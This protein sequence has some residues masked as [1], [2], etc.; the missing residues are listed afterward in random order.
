MHYHFLAFALLVLSGIFGSLFGAA[1]EDRSKDVSPAGSSAIVTPVISQP[2]HSC[3]DG[4]RPYARG[5]A[6]WYG[7]GFHGKLMANG[8]RYDMERFTVAHKTLPLG[9]RVCITNRAN[10]QSVTAT[11]T[12]RGPYSGK[13]II[14]LSRRV[15][16]DLG[17]MHAGLGSVE[18]FLSPQTI[19]HGI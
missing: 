2:E 8:K 17:I 16:R 13:R 4:G 7:P 9:T 15:A 10:G 3:D 12:D 11:V 18:I 5:I 6:S 19:P 14:D 1:P